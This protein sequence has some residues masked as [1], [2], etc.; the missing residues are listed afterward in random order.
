[1]LIASG[2]QAL[3]LVCREGKAYQFPAT[4]ATDAGTIAVMLNQ[5]FQENRERRF[6]LSEVS[7]SDMQ[8]LAAIA[9]AADQA[10]K[11]HPNGR[12][13][14]DAIMQK[15]SIVPIHIE[16]QN[17]CDFL[18]YGTGKELVARHIARTNHR[19]PLAATFYALV[20]RYYFLINDNDLPNTEPATCGFSIQDYLDYQPHRVIKKTDHVG[21]ELSK[22]RL[23]SLFGLAAVPDSTQ[24]HILD[25]QLNHIKELESGIFTGFSQLRHLCLYH[26]QIKELQAGTFRGL[27]Q[28]QGLDLSDNQI[29][30]IEPGSLTGLSQ[31]K[32]LSLRSNQISELQN[33]AFAGL[34][35]LQ[36]LDL[37]YNKIKKLQPGIFR[38]LLRLKKLCLQSNQIEELQP[39]IFAD[40]P[41]LRKLYIAG[42]PTSQA[43]ARIISDALATVEVNF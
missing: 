39:E 4:F 26:N 27:S 40:L 43:H 28:L 22:L 13:L 9:H 33:G 19:I 35:Q 30:E 41:Q 32:E 11:Q 38:G 42:N 21:A 2:C 23:N 37:G 17:I 7:E 14:L 31:L 20:A 15:I 1:M 6:Y 24:L 12:A 5:G 25:L 3:E 8:A 10:K 34:S 18:D 29:K 36:R 16:F